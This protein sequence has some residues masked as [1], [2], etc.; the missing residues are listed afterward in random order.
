MYTGPYR[1]AQNGNPG[2][3]DVAQK[4]SEHSQ[5]HGSRW[6]EARTNESWNTFVNHSSG[7][8]CFPRLDAHSAWSWPRDAVPALFALV[9][10]GSSCAH[11]P[12]EVAVPSSRELAPAPPNF[13]SEAERLPKDPLEE[14]KQYWARMDAYKRAAEQARSFRALL[15]MKDTEQLATS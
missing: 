7:S 1:E 11:R 14:R 9:V 13:E 5:Q 12:A 8:R 4:N 15:G 10:L 3:N 6:R 2:T